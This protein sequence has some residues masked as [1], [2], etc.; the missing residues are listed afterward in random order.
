MTASSSRP[1]RDTAGKPPRQDRAVQTRAQTL[2]AAAEL[3]AEQGYPATSI[4]DVA[5]R[6][7][8]TKGAVYFHFRNK[9]DMAVEVV[10]ELY[11]RWVA[12][13]E[14]VR[15]LGLSP[16]SS[17]RELMDRAGRTFVDDVIVKAGARLQAERSL[18][19]TTL[20]PPYIDWIGTASAL[21]TEA[22]AAGELRPGVDPQAAARVMVS[23]FFGAQ[24]I[25]DILH[26]RT[27]LA[28]RWAEVRELVFY[29]IEAH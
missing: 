3:F 23:S 6:V 19:A 16:L 12:L 17:L 15:E 20:P 29:S 26:Q 2:N 21:L 24:H 13:V 7:G 14:D 1:T 8:M 5:D 22:Q 28:D 18:I 27:D 4:V 10:R 9:E 25:S 11:K